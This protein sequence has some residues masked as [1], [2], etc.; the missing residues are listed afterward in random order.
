MLIGVDMDDV[1]AELMEQLLRYHN[2]EI[3]SGFSK[4]DGIRAERARYVAS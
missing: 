1:L 3:G 2:L 4:R